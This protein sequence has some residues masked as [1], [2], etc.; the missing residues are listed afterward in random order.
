MTE[1][2]KQ[3]KP[4]LIS[5]DKIKDHI[6][7]HNEL[8]KELFGRVLTEKEL[9]LKINGGLTSED[10]LKV[11]DSMGFRPPTLEE[12]DAYKQSLVPSEKAEE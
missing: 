6:K 1:S 11:M 5:P 8:Q 4:E 7:G 9:E 12:I 3:E 2:L 10:I